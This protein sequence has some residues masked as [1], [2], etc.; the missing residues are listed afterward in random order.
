MKNK[1]FQIHDTFAQTSLKLFDYH[2][3]QYVGIIM[4]YL[5]ICNHGVF[6]D[7]HYILQPLEMTCLYVMKESTEIHAQTTGV[8]P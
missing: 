3:Y 5:M 8:Y 6:N 7:M 1:G 4:G 2:S